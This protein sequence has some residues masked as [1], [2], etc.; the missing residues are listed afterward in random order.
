MLISQKRVTVDGNVASVGDRVSTESVVEVDG[1]RLPIDPEFVTW[2]LYKPA[3]V[4]STMS[5][6]Q[7]RPTVRDLVPPE[8]VT[9]PVGRLDLHSEGL[10]LMTNDGELQNAVTHPR[11]GVPKTYHV[12]VP[13]RL[14]QSE[15]APFTE[16]IELED[17]LAKARTTRIVT[18]SKDRCIVE[19]VMTEG[20]KREIR[21]MFDAAG[22]PILSLVRVRIGTITDRSL[23]PGT[24]R[25][26]TLEEVRSLYQIAGQEERNG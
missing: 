12:L 1:V 16:G 26:L 25:A 20:K 11:Y 9:N 19:L 2:L 5:D 6:P 10:L 24:Y 8:P 13:R 23:T 14:K 18:S 3:G 15:L 21:R 4:V 7:G 17:G 22:L